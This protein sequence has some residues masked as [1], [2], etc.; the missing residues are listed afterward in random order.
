MKET[1]NE[2]KVRDFV[3]TTQDP[4][5]LH[6]NEYM[7]NTFGI[8]AL[9]PGM[10]LLCGALGKLEA[11]ELSNINYGATYFVNAVPVGSSVDFEARPQRKHIF[12]REVEGFKISAN[13]NGVDALSDKE[14]YSFVRKIPV[15]EVGG[16]YETP[17]ILSI[18]MNDSDLAQFEELTHIPANFSQAAFALTLSSASID[19]Q[20]RNPVTPAFKTLNEGVVVDDPTVRKI[21]TY[22]SF[23]FYMPQ[24]FRAISQKMSLN[25]RSAVMRDKSVFTIDTICYDQSGIVY[26]A[27][28]R[29][30]QSRQEVIVK[31]VNGILDNV[32]KSGNP[33]GLEEA[34]KRRREIRDAKNDAPVDLGNMGSSVV[35]LG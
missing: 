3:A 12:S 7:W 15:R 21:P 5:F 2:K 6:D 10:Q 31:A 23:E 11:S 26:C 27:R 24:G 30:K 34:L 8:P 35:E 29:L 14:E 28:A 16:F 4:N 1:I 13:A 18:R 32:E 25:L 19:T 9:V 33:N 17:S 20:L 22:Q